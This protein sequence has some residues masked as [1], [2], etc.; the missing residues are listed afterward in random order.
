[1]FGG[2]EGGWRRRAAISDRESRKDGDFTNEL[3]ETPSGRG[4]ETPR[5]QPGMAVPQEIVRTWGAMM[6]HTYAG[7]GEGV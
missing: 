3:V 4:E 2:I 6:L 7:N 1:M 5:T